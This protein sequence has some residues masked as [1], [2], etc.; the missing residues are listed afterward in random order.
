MIIHC[1]LIFSCKSNPTK[2]VIEKDSSIV[3]PDTA[4]L[5]GDIIFQSTSSGGSI[6][7]VTNSKYSHCGLILKENNVYF[8]LE[9]IQPVSI[10]DLQS[11]IDRG[12]NKKYVVKRLKNRNKVLTDSTVSFMKKIGKSYLNKPYDI[13]FLWNDERIYCS[14]L[15]WKVYKKST[16]LEVGKLQK[17]KDFNLNKNELKE[18]LKSRWG[19]AVPYDETVISPQAIYESNLLE[20]IKE[21]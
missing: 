4:L 12:N 5:D 9:A 20:T 8:V 10:T 19:N 21:K 2:S 11:W 14:E 16:G 18:E 6:E 3:H 17:L 13:E 7:D 15:V 1:F